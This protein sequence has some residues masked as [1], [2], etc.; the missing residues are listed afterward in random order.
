MLYGVVQAYNP[1]DIL[2]AQFT[3]DIAIIEAIELAGA[4]WTIV[5]GPG[6]YAENV[7][8][9]KPLTL[10]TAEGATIN[11]SSGVAVHIQSSDVTVD[12][13]NLTTGGLDAHGVRISVGATG[14]TI[15]GNTITIGG[16]STA[17]YADTN[18]VPEESK[19]S[20]WLISGNTLNAPAGVNLE[21]YD[22]DAV[23]IDGNVFGNTAGS[24]VIVSSELFNLSTIAF[25]NN[26]VQG[27][28]GGS[29][30]AF[31]TDFQKFIT[32][33]R[34]DTVVTTMDNVTITGNT[35]DGWADR[36]LRIGDWGGEVTNVVANF[37]NF[38]AGADALVNYATASVD[39]TNNWWGQVSG[40]LGGQIVEVVGT[41][42]STPWSIALH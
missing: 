13:F 2:M 42:L 35:F 40:P 38:L 39:A 10:Q 23:T 28:G 30:V 3:G 9:D 20:N 22:V 6:T 14:I 1:T 11:P 16:G 18:G 5:V 19:S 36:G 26:D 32:G 12:G 41:V 8:I 17:I 25:T 33:T 29:M 21:L 34:S 15:T 27:N 7:L 4:N 24:N 37:N 31:V